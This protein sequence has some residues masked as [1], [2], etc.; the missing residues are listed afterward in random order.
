M[1]ANF[2]SVRH[3]QTNRI[4]SNKCGRNPLR[5]EKIPKAACLSLRNFPPEYNRLSP[6]QEISRMTSLIFFT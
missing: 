2:R 6:H 3:F 5:H 4:F 1:S